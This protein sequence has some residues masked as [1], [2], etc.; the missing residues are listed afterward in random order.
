MRHTNKTYRAYL[1][2]KAAHESVNQVRKY[3]GE[4]YIVHPVAVAELVSAVT[5]DE[6]MIC[7]ALLHDTIEDT[8]VEAG[9]I[10]AA[11]G[12]PVS[13]LVL[14]VTDVSKKEDGNREVRKRLDREHIA[15]AS[16]RGKTV[17]LA[18]LIDNTRTILKYDEEFARTYMREKD[19]LLDVLKQGNGFLWKMARGIVDD[20]FK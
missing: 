2:A 11:F 16:V 3:T 15:R 9:D 19:A 4:P 20:Y 6:D 1:F 8:K 17:K 7:A 10:A 12:L 13:N 18:D 5:E 14:E